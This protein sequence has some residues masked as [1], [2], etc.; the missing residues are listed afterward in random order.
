MG[1]MVPTQPAVGDLATA[2][3]ADEVAQ[4]VIDLAGTEQVL[5]FTPGGALDTPAAGTATWLTVGNVTV[6]TWATK[7]IASFTL[8]GVYCIGATAS[9]TSVIKIGT[10]AG[11][12]S[13]IITHPGVANQRFQL[14][15]FDKLTGVSTG[16]QSV[17][18]S[19]TFSSG[20]VIRADGT[21]FFAGTFRFQP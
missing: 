6:P 2:A 14:P 19:A 21:S 7:C 18:I 13:K 4:D 9:T 5:L 3:W 12:V 11:A 17:T 15:V 1:I 20:S 16:S 10:V 8:S